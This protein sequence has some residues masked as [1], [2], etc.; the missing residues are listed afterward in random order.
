MAVLR[1]SMGKTAGGQREEWVSRATG[2]G[3]AAAEQGIPVAAAGMDALRAFLDALTQ[4]ALLLDCAGG[5][6]LHINAPAL[7]LSGLSAAEFHS[8]TPGWDPCGVAPQAVCCLPAPHGA[9]IPVYA[10][11][12]E[13]QSAGAA[14]RLALL[15]PAAPH[16]RPHP[17]PQSLPARR[18]RRRSRRPSRRAAR[19]HAV[20]EALNQT[21]S[22]EDVA[23]V[24]VEQ[25]AAA[26][27]AI[28]GAFFVVEQQPPRLVMLRS[29]GMDASTV[30]RFHQVPLAI[31]RPGTEA[32]RTGVPVW[33][34]NH[35]EL[36]RHYPEMAADTSGAGLQAGA[37]LPVQVGDQVAAVLT[38]GFAT[39]RAFS[40]D[41]QTE[42]LTLVRQS[43]LAIER[44]QLL[45]AEEAARTHAADIVASTTDA[46]FAIDRS[47]RVSYANHHAARLM[48]TTPEQLLGKRPWRMFAG[49]NPDP[50]RHHFLAA[51]DEG[52]AAAFEVYA[53]SLD[54]WL[55][56]HV[57]PSAVGVYVSMRDVTQRRRA[58]D[59]L[60]M[61]AA[62]LTAQSEAAIDGVLIIDRQMRIFSRNQRWFSL[63]NLPEDLRARDSAQELVSAALDSVAEPDVFLAWVERMRADPDLTVRQELNLR[64]GRI[65]DSYTAPV[66]S[67][68]GE[69]LG[70]VIYVRDVT[71]PRR[72]EAALRASE[73]RYR[74]QF[75]GFP[76]PAF[77]W[78]QQAEDFVLVAYNHA[79][80]AVTHGRIE[81]ML[82]G[83]AGDF[84]ADAPEVVADLRRCAAGTAAGQRSRWYRFYDGGEA[85]YLH[86]TYT[87][88]PDGLVIVHTEDA[89]D[90]QQAESALRESEERFRSL[91]QNVSDVIVILEE[92]GLFRYQ[93]PAMERVLGWQLQEVAGTDPALLLHPDDVPLASAA[94]AR[95]VEQPATPAGAAFRIR[96][97][98]GSWRT[99][100]A[101]FTNMLANPAVGGLVVHARDITERR[102]AEQAL[103]R[104]DAIYHAAGVAAARFL[105]SADWEQHIPD[106]LARLGVAAQVSRVYLFEQLI[107]EDGHAVSRQRFEWASPGVPA[108]IDNPALQTLSFEAYEAG[109]IA[110]T[111]A[112]GAV[113]QT[114]TRDLPAVFR[115]LLDAQ[116][117]LSALLVP[118]FAGGQYWGFLGFDE[119]AA[120]RE[121]AAAE[122]DALQ[123]AART[124][125]AAVQR[126]REQQALAVSEE[127]FRLLA[128]N[129]RDTIFRLR[130]RPLLQWDYI[131]PSVEGITGHTPD[132]LYQDPRLALRAVHPEDAYILQ[133]VITEPKRFDGPV[134]LRFIHRNGSTCWL[135]MRIVPVLD[136]AGQVVAVEGVARDISERRRAEQSLRESETRFRSLIQHISDVITVVDVDGRIRYH[137]PSIQ[138][139][140][141]YD[142]DALTGH[143]AREIVHPDDLPSLQAFFRRAL[144]NQAAGSP[145]ELRIRHHDGAWRHVESYAVALL[146]EPGVRGIVLTSRDVTERKQ[147]EEQL[148]HLAFHDALTGLPNRA[149]FL[150]RLEHALARA[151]RREGAVAVLFLD[152]DRFKVVNDS[153]GHAAGDELLATVARRLR[154]CLRPSDTL[155][156]FGGDEFTV[157][158]EHI[159]RPTDAASVAERIIETLS[160][161]VSIAGHEVVATASVGIVLNTD[162]HR[163]PADLLR[164]ADLALYQAKGAGRARY[165][166]FDGA[167]HERAVERLTMEADLRRALER[168]ELVLHYQPEVE[169]SSGRIAGMEALL[170]WQ[171]PTRGLI[172][173]GEFIPLAEETGLIIPISEWVLQTACRQA[174][175]WQDGRRRGSPSLLLSVNLSPQQFRHPNLLATISQALE[176]SRL[177]PSC[178]R[179]EITEGAVV[180]GAEATVATMLA[181]KGLGVRLAID[182]FGTGY[183]SL[184]YLTRFAVDTLKVDRSFVLGVAHDQR[185]FSVVKAVAAIAHALGMDVTAEGIETAEQLAKVRGVKCD[186]GQGFY[187][188]RPMPADRLTAIL[189]G[190]M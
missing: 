88:V 97:K 182:D 102:Q 186:W 3:P 28:M 174:R 9:T 156:R 128:E 189:R 2:S 33:F 167:A 20:A 47:W 188:F 165:V 65:F 93:S 29:T 26:C 147:F 78:Q 179:L 50:I 16:S 151:E 119:C 115:Q 122:V 176:E 36:A 108:K 92:S 168:D 6:L 5:G 148:T 162:G 145:L 118:V 68:D 11:I 71:A 84:Y 91:V 181:L 175:Y 172:P 136:H 126:R 66:R 110:A 184:S 171:H 43:S 138:R 19:M 1:H 190:G 37:A 98:D 105:S 70:R 48:N 123:M 173:P 155:A 169:L 135:E 121:W 131:G 141:G 56:V 73:E 144:D 41:D 152:L 17:A 42:L 12:S 7:A 106:V 14:V 111:L 120:E 21:H 77:A 54:R 44:V 72:A 101:I 75:M 163:H 60:R 127:R 10:V 24:L 157:L 178:L 133:G 53:D 31:H 61:Q 170:R 117:V 124:L 55:D 87:L 34:E 8:L 30:D 46:I 39:S 38:L 113:V 25:G 137:S 107:A 159:S 52:R 57:R 183:S 103:R 142:P 100:E 64:D 99:F 15:Q 32:A 85:R 140:L 45:R 63:W 161:P 58:D 80:E 166:L 177:D 40:A 81:A 160:A 139:V 129:A 62:V 125:G 59:A 116:S 96:H 149:L 67:P 69:T 132:E 90:R 114:H 89:T 143:E 27:G 150:N 4:P 134:E 112:T 82:G 104:Q 146:D 18:N 51:M 76:V 74:A 79:A 164:D 153:L 49:Q 130:L 83:R 158:L 22:L 23:A 154:G 86:F 95:V 109:H 180:D 185:T 35:A 187:F 13:V 94:L